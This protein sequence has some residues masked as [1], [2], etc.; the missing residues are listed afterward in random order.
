MLQNDF[1][2]IRSINRE[3]DSFRVLLE[4]NAVHKIFEGHFPGQP[5]V[6]GAC[7]M[8]MIQE[9]A[10][11]VLGRSLRLFRADHLKFISF[12]V[13]VVDQVLEMRFTYIIK[14]DSSLNVSGELSANDSG[15]LL[16]KSKLC[17]KFRG[18]SFRD[19]ELR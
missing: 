4:L 1:F 17:L 9:T 14:E 5:V 8:Q 10:E 11:T 2:T 12:I 7:L 13:P 18:L 19:G 6:P 3:G 15:D 16:E